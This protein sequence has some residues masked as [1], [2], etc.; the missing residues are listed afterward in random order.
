MGSHSTVSKMQMFEEGFRVPM[1]LRQ[2]R[3]VPKGAKITQA[4]SGYDLYPTVLDLCGV[5][6]NTK[7][8][9]V[10]SLRGTFRSPKDWPEYTF[11][12]LGGP[13]RGGISSQSAT[14]TGS[15]SCRRK[16]RR[17]CITPPPIRANKRTC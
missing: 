3:R 15:W 5:E 9:A 2:P 13:G 16:R 1:I 14:G 7:G 11:G 17:G 4:V 10:R 6:H 12:E 8:L